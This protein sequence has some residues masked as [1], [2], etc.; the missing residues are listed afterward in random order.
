MQERL[1]PVYPMLGKA[2]V[3]VLA[4]VKRGVGGVVPVSGV[5]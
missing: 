5:D 4:W 1:W 2:E 3:P